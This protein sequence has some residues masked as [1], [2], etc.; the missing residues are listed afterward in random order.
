MMQPL[1]INDSHTIY[2]VDDIEACQNRCRSETS[3]GHYTFYA[4]L[5]TCH[6]ALPMAHKVPSTPGFWAGDSSCDA[7]G[8]GGSRSSVRTSTM[9]HMCFSNKESWLPYAVS[10]VEAKTPLECQQAC[11]NRTSC[12]HFAFNLLTKECDLSN[13]NATNS[14]NAAYQISGPPECHPVVTFDMTI[15]GMDFTKVSE[16]VFE[17]LKQDGKDNFV[18]YFGEWEPYRKG[19]Q[20]DLNQQL[21]IAK[22]ITMD[23]GARTI[24]NVTFLVKIRTTSYRAPYI[25][26]ILTDP[27]S[28][29]QIQEQV[30][31]KVDWAQPWLSQLSV[32]G[33]TT[34]RL[35]SEGPALITPAQQTTLKD[36]VLKDE[37][38]ASNSPVL[39]LRSLSM[40]AVFG[41][42]A[43]LALGFVAV[44]LRS[45][46][47]SRSTSRTGH[48]SF[49]PLP[50]DVEGNADEDYLST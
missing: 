25:L 30:D 48:L 40:F 47:A 13:E 21:L 1:T 10:D 46:S 9:S 37:Y 43:L 27:L 35:I 17:Q 18:E 16:A 8:S 41:S 26:K 39:Q 22:N 3:C 15:R 50:E 36:I 32:A 29:K 19:V 11:A 6:L 5:K 28:S 31:R 44:Y 34:P 23:T 24:T 7:S 38:M 20:Q 49:S 4:P 33:I 12:A 45:R 14:T 42:L 2:Q